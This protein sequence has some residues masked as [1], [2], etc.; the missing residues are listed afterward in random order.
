M[1]LERLPPE[2]IMNVN[3]PT[4][5]PL[6]Y[7]LPEN[8][9]VLGRRYL[10]DANAVA[11]KMQKV[12]NQGKAKAWRT[13]MAACKSNIVLIGMSGVG[14][15]TLGARLAKM[16]GIGFVDTDALIEAQTGERLADTIRRI[17]DEAF[18][19]LEESVLLA[20]TANR[21]VIATGGSA[22][23]SEKG[24]SALR[25]NGIVVYLSVPYSVIACRVKN[26]STRG[27]VM[28]YGRSL[29]ETYEDRLVLYQRYAD[30]TIQLANKRVKD[31]TEE[32]V[33]AL[34]ERRI[35]L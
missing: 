28:R 16:L 8:G 24:M 22:V 29:Q 13:H 34:Q 5:I 32:L 26:A 18:L 35:T 4:G 3:L 21:T 17:G 30:I 14:K 10:G 15:T 12:A 20:L 33:T 11:M 23:Y 2:E 19:R 9:R 1:H 27:I 6:V 25:H 31:S 7:E